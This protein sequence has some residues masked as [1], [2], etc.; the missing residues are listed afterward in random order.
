[1]STGQAN[2][3]AQVDRVVVSRVVDKVVGPEA[4]G[5]AVDFEGRLQ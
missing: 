5:K 1:M 2:V 3:V 4:E